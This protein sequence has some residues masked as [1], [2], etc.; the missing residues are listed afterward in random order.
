MQPNRFMG[1]FTGMF[2][3][4]DERMCK[5]CSLLL[6][7]HFREICYNDIPNAYNFNLCKTQFA[8]NIRHSTMHPAIGSN[9][10]FKQ[11]SMHVQCSIVRRVIQSY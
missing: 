8:Q 6:Q 7:K 2:V 4:L 10:R 5:C 1:Q 3:E 9:V 11:I